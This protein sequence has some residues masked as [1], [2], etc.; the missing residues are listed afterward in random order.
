MTR[1]EEVE[2]IASRARREIEA[3]WERFDGT[4][5]QNADYLAAES[6]RV[7]TQAEVIRI[8]A[9][10]AMDAVAAA[11]LLD[12]CAIPSAL[13]ASEGAPADVERDPC[14]GCSLPLLRH[15]LA[16]EREFRQR[17]R[18]SVEASRDRLLGTGDAEATGALLMADEVLREM[19]RIKREVLGTVQP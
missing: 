3:L 10:I 13:S 4:C 8:K 6:I 17:L 11:V 15:R 9:S 1:G 12:A 19:E 16:L 14:A 18:W 5:N 7:K 2:R